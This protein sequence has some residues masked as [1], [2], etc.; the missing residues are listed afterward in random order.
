MPRSDKPISTGS[1][2]DPVAP[3][4]SRTWRS[5]ANPEDSDQFEPEGLSL[6]D[7]LTQEP[8]EAVVNLM[9]PTKPTVTIPKPDPAP[10]IVVRPPVYEWVTVQSIEGRTYMRHDERHE[11]A[12]HE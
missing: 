3:A 5:H 7:P 11:I 10:E 8:V 12:E 4:R 2:S 1:L 6:A 9:N